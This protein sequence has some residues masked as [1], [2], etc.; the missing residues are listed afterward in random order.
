MKQK[1][2]LGDAKRLL[3][4]FNENQSFSSQKL[5][6]RKKSFVFFYTR[7]H[8]SACAR[9]MFSVVIGIRL[10]SVKFHRVRLSAL[11]QVLSCLRWQVSDSSAMCHRAFGCAWSNSIASC[12]YRLVKFFCVLV[13]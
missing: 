7:E 8:L 12:A 13:Q 4:I 10:Y 6:E 5:L 11:R 3:C 9:S 1:R 2:E